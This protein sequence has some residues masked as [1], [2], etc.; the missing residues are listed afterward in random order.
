MDAPRQSVPVVSVGVPVFNGAQRLEQTLDSIL[1]QTL[2]DIEIVISDNGST[3][4]T[5][6]ICARYADRDPRIRVFRQPRNIGLPLNWNFVARQARGKFFKWASANDLLAPNMLA[7]CVESLQD[8]PT[9]VLAFSGTALVDADGSVLEEHQD[10]FA[11]LDDSPSVRFRKLC[12]WIGLN[13]AVHGVVRREALLKTGL[14]RAYPASDYV[15]MA[16]LALQGKFKLLPQTLFYRRTD[17]SSITTGLERIERLRLHKP[18]SRGIESIEFRRHADL[19]MVA[20]TTQG[21]SFSERLKSLFVAIRHTIWARREI[22]A[23]LGESLR[24][25]LPSKRL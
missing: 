1:A 15:V 11:L 17:P 9:A 20:L 2:S 12:E 10:E 14:I 13:H 25:L 21:V 3:D 18:A 23:D 7:S 16:E 19:I 8:D 5:P 4:E 24:A 6:A 22:F